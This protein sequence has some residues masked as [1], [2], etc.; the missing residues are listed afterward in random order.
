MI[1]QIW[2]IQA[3]FT[4]IDSSLFANM[5]VNIFGN[6]HGWFGNDLMLN[7]TI[8]KVNSFLLIAIYTVVNRYYETLRLPIIKLTCSLVFVY[9]TFIF[10]HVC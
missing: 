4:Y 7:S 8:V 10:P 5:I 6:E 9:I 1:T 2:L 3:F